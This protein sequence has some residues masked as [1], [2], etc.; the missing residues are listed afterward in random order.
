[1]GRGWRDKCLPRRL[2]FHPPATRPEPRRALLTCGAEAGVLRGRVAD[3]GGRR[4][5]FH[6]RGRLRWREGRHWRRGRRGRIRQDNLLLAFR[7]GGS[8]AG[9]QSQGQGELS[10]RGFKNEVLSLVCVMPHL[11]LKP[12]LGAPP[13]LA[14]RAMPVGTVPTLWEKKAGRSRGAGPARRPARVGIQSSS[15]RAGGGVGWHRG[16][17]QRPGNAGSPVLP[18]PFMARMSSLARS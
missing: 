17:G 10:L 5:H 1:M 13:I 11:C 6:G 8:R 15:G 3:R 2:L 18:S 16:A 14:G 4:R 12:C 7:C 9:S